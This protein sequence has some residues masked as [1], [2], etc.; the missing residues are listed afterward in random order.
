MPV[1]NGPISTHKTL[2]EGGMIFG[3]VT[4]SMLPGFALALFLFFPLHVMTKGEYKLSVPPA[5][6]VLLGYWIYVGNDREKAWRN[7]CKHAQNDYS[8]V[9]IGSTEN[10]ALL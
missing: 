10:K 9:Y 4:E 3:V 7:L 2:G 5:L 1:P 6:A 8:Q